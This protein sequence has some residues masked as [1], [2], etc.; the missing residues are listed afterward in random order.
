[1]S[2]RTNDH[3]TYMNI[4]IYILTKC[5]L[6]LNSTRPKSE[7]VYNFFSV[8]DWIKTHAKATKCTK[9]HR[10]NE[11]ECIYNKSF[12]CL[13]RQNIHEDIWCV[14]FRHRRINMKR[15]RERK[16]RIEKKN[17]RWSMTIKRV[18]RAWK[19]NA[20]PFSICPKRI[21]IESYYYIY[22]VSVSV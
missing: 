2:K 8:E 19:L 1:M 12:G 21:L 17:V 22:L 3:S 5:R 20:V 18:Q 16:F 10:R 9:C 11:N 15:E 4:Y 13:K 14:V 6:K 7:C